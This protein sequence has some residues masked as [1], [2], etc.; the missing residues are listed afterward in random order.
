MRSFSWLLGLSLLVA[1]FASVG[2]AQARRAPSTNQTVATPVPVV[3]VTVQNP[4]EINIG[5]P[6]TFVLSVTNQGKAAANNVVVETRVPEHAELTGTTPQPSEVEGTIAKFQI[7]DLA[8]GATR[9]VT[10]VAVPKT[11]DVIKVGATTTFS[12]ATQSTL[13]VR[14]PMLKLLAQTAPSV[15]IG[16]EANWLLRVVNTGDGH[17]DDIVVTP[18]LVE[19]EVQGT[20]L[21]AVRIGALKPGET[22]E[23]QFTVIPTK[24]GKLAA[25]FEGT[26]A[27][28]LKAAVDST[29]QVLQAQLAVKAVGPVVQPIG[30]E[31]SYEIQ[32]T[33]PGD[34][35][36][37][38]TMVVVKIPAGLEVT[39]AAQNSYDKATRTLRWRI[40]KVR[41]TDV[42]R[43]PFR[44]ETVTAGEQTLSVL[45]ESNKIEDATTT[46]T[47]AVISRSNLIVTVV[48]DQELAE[49]QDPVGFKVTVVNAGSRPVE[50]LR[51]NV[52][53]PEGLSAVDASTYD[54]ADGKISF[55][56]QKLASGEKVTLTFQAVGQ[57]VGEHRVRVLVSGGALTRELSFEGSTYCYSNDEVPVSTKK[58]G[59]EAANATN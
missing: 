9:R 48:N 19:G 34:A 16:A 15:S 13:I 40:T 31:G 59:S 50:D 5:K 36:T 23:V 3:Q 43:L 49:V 35:A 51:V 2:H 56:T 7:G 42:V 22:K 33:N 52:A 12:T 24:R 14:Q 11:T 39:A 32:V 18:K 17:A 37:G 57:R 54:V 29:I 58:L 38:S 25:S 41:P 20:P 47:T 10:L 6:A 45:A 53:M 26:N 28:G 55:P 21:R 4:R 46:H 1:T 30:R 44:A 27:D 8:P